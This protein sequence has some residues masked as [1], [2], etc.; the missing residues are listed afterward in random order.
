MQVQFKN[1]LFDSAAFVFAVA[2]GQTL[3]IVLE[4]AEIELDFATESDALAAAAELGEL[5]NSV[6]SVSGVF[7][8]AATAVSGLLAGLFS[9]AKTKVTKT[10]TAKSAEDVA[11]TLTDILE[12]AL[13]SRPTARSNASEAN[14]VFGTTRTDRTDRADTVVSDLSD[15]ALRTAIEDKA[16][17]LLASDARVQAMVAQLR[18][19]YSDSQVD[20]VIEERKEQVFQFARANGN[21][22]LNQIVAQILR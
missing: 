5:L 8:E 18:R 4:T 11:T 2:N 22:T 14:S 9:T 15:A 13:S 19:F 1:A 21:L 20:E 16:T 12:Q 17:T 7:T 6:G 3:T 10:G